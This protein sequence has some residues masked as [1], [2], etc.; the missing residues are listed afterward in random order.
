[1]SAPV[2]AAGISIAAARRALAES[3]RL[4]GVDTP[5]LDARLLVGHALGLD[6]TGLATAAERA[7]TP[8]ETEAI[9]G[10]AMRRLAHEPVARIVGK[11]EFWGLALRVTPAVLVPRPDTE[12]VVEAAL[13]A[14]GRS[15]PRS[16]ALRIVDIGVGSGA[17]LL[18]ILSELPNASGVGT[19]R[20]LAAIETA[21]SN[22]V[23][24]GLSSR[25]AFVAC[26]YGAALSG[27]FDMVVSNPPYIPT[28]HIATLAPEVRDF[29]PRPA[30]DGGNDGLDAYRADCRRCPAAARARRRPG[31]RAGHRPERHGGRAPGRRRA[32]GRVADPDRPRGHPARPLRG[33]QAMS[34]SHCGHAKNTKKAL[35]L[36]GRTH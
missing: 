28:N 26:D 34:T 27:G 25:A 14:A 20:S 33:P 24:L 13:A 36:S 12:T 9:A 6:H 35:G 10:L 16:R 30:L 1:M 23:R 4:A 18:A 5:E 11:K 21:R 3:F 7:L 31:A 22:A 8:P 19:D 15:G 17:L 2:L 32:Q 29:E